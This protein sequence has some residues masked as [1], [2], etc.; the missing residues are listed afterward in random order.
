[1][2]ARTYTE[3]GQVKTAEDLARGI[4][5]VNEREQ[6]LGAIALHYAKTGKISQAT[7]IA[8]SLKTA[9]N[10]TLSNIVEHLLKT[11][12]YEQALQVARQ[13]KVES[14][15][16]QVAL[17]FA[18][19]GKPPQ[20]LQI[21]ESIKAKEPA[22]QSS[23]LDWLM[24]AIVQSFAQQGQFE[25]ALKVAQKIQTKENQSAALT[26]IAAQYLKTDRNANQNKAT[27]I[28]DQAMKVALSI[29]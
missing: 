28:L 21:A 2:V 20:A 22:R 24:P 25:Q 1:M 4:T 27:A 17:A 19:A 7:T 10:L 13:E 5:D 26:R 18:E 12:Q 6:V 16:P 29:R 9:K 3:I 14:I 8:R 23:H 11:K 15:L